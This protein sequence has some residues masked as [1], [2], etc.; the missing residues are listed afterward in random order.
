MEAI[1]VLREGKQEGPFSRERIQELIATQHIRENT[2]IWH[3]GLP[4]WTPLSLT[5]LALAPKPSAEN[6]RSV[7]VENLTELQASVR[8]SH[9]QDLPLFEFREFS[10]GQRLF[11]RYDLVRLIG[12]GGMGLVWLARD[13]VLAED[14]ALKFLPETVRLDPVAVE[15]LKRETRRSR[16]L[17]HAHIVKVYDFIGDGRCAAIAMEFINGSSLS[18]LRAR[19]QHLCF[20][21]H[22]IQS[23]M[24][25]LIGAFTYAHEKARLV[26]RDLKPANV[27]IDH[28][29]EAKVTDFGIA[30]SI[31]ENV[32]RVTMQQG[33]S[34]TIAYMSPQQV[35][36][37]APS[38]KDDI[39]SL[40]ATIFE[41]L[42]SQPPF[43]RGDISRQISLV[44]PPSLAERR[45][46][47]GLAA[48]DIPAAWEETIA[49]C[50]AKE[51]ADRPASMNEVG[52]RLGL[53]VPGMRRAPIS[54]PRLLDTADEPLQLRVSE[55]GGSN[56]RRAV[57]ALCLFMATVFC[58]VGYYVLLDK[59][60]G[61]RPGALSAQ[62]A[63]V[64]VVSKAASALPA[65]ADPTLLSAPAGLTPFSGTGAPSSPDSVADL[66][67]GFSDHGKINNL[68]DT[69]KAKEAFDWCL[70][71]AAQG[72][73]NGRYLAGYCY[74]NGIGT[75]VN[76]TAALR[77]FQLAADQD[78][79][80]SEVALSE[81]YFLGS[82]T[83]RDEKKAV[84]WLRKAADQGDLGAINRMGYAYSS[85]V[86]LPQDIALAIA[87]WRKGAEQGGSDAQVSLA[88]CYRD[89]VGLKKDDGQA[90]F[91]FQKSA[92]QQNANAEAALGRMYLNG[93]GVEK[94]FR[95][96]FELFSEAANSPS[97]PSRPK[98]DLAILYYKGL[99][100]TRDLG[101]ALYWFQA[102][103]K[104][105]NMSE[106][107]YYLGTIYENGEGVRKDL[108]FALHWYQEAAPRWPL[109]K[110]ACA[111]LGCPV[112]AE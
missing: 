81:V 47:L 96:A 52:M 72:D 108:P 16:K 106:A 4:A 110:E 44:T 88:S 112:A 86:G 103:A 68:G 22:E 17:A 101:Q 70:K 71:A 77:Y 10:A 91:W 93:T 1:F 21:V 58:L 65:S 41:L 25:D 107:Q 111:R 29:G 63:P 95:K 6:S 13:E 12:R 39:Y 99:G 2:Q 24:E 7:L 14:I 64:T 3:Q 74:Q 76:A 32:S 60:K 83:P 26:H 35:M 28:H 82:G 75:K 97:A 15:E 85:G 56:N 18:G 89:G 55:T 36:G 102:A 43:Y 9:S 105:T 94:D 40:G 23:W 92:D 11:D 30:G 67:A 59:S 34:G 100:V 49:A 5:A 69:Q 53:N 51:P 45:E 57:I 46:D 87:W 42:T 31:A 79:L 19:K 98:C 48:I 73:A 38:P 62:G 90:L 37:R 84:D 27:M 20:E 54:L 78:F 104:D 66:F 80:K 109:A 8:S 33:G 61:M 50:L